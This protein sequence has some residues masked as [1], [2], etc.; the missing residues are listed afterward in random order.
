MTNDD[1]ETM[2]ILFGAQIG[3]LCNQGRWN[4]AEGMEGIRDRLIQALESQSPCDLCKYNPPSSMD[5]KPC[6]VCPAEGRE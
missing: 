3:E 1:I 2:R 5:G 6:S 4:D